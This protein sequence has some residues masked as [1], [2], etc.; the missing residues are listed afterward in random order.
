MYALWVK[1]IYTYTQEQCG[2]STDLQLATEPEKVEEVLHAVR[3]HRNANADGRAGSNQVSGGRQHATGG[4][5]TY[6]Y[7]PAGDVQLT[8]RKVHTRAAQVFGM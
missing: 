6:T 1:K 8:R 5:R 2:S 7:P 3:G 4:G